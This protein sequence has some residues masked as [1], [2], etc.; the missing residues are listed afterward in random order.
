MMPFNMRSIL[1]GETSLHCMRA[2]CKYNEKLT[3]Y[4]KLIQTKNEKKCR[5]YNEKRCLCKI[6]I[7]KKENDSKKV[8]TKMKVKLLYN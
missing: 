5:N 2:R 7:S 4:Y 8:K 1:K 3:V 6:I